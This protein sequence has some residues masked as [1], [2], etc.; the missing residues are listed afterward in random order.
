MEMD[1]IMTDTMATMKTNKIITFNCNG[2][3]ANNIYIEKIINE[4][5]TIFLTE[6][7][8]TQ[9]EKYL[10]H[11]YKKDFH[12]YSQ[13][14]HNRPTLWRQRFTSQKNIKSQTRTNSSRRI[15]HNC[16]S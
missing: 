12:V 2:F 14:R 10:L 16:Q 13:T 1:N 3:K 6:L 7:W 8:I 11:N 5:D 15:Y 9:S 4:N